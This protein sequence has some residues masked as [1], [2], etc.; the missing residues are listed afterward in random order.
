VVAVGTGSKSLQR[1]RKQ[2]LGT[3]DTPGSY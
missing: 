1:Q 3:P 2:G